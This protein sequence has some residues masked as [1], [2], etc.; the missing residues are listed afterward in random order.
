MF[1]LDPTGWAAST[2]TLYILA[3]LFLIGFFVSYARFEV[4]H[5]RALRDGGEAVLVY[6]NLLR[7]FPNLVYAKMFG[8]RPLEV[9]KDDKPG[10]GQP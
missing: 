2:W 6:N 7:G 5:R 9:V 3:G 1:D 8:K 4:A 10:E